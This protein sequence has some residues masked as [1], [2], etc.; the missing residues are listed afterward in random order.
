MQGYIKTYLLLGSCVL[1]LSACSTVSKVFDEKENPPIEGKRLSVL[2]LQK[3]LE[4]DSTAIEQ[5][6]VILPEIWQNE[7]WPQA[8]GLPNHAMHNLAWESGDVDVLWRADIGSGSHNEIPLTAQPVIVKDVIYA[9]DTESK[10]SAINAQNGKKIWGIDV[11]NKAEDEDVIGGGIAFANGMLFITNGSNEILSV[12]VSEGKIIWRANL[13]T[14]ARAA[15]TALGGRVFVST[16]DDRLFAIDAEKGT[17]IWDYLGIGETTGLLGAASPAANTSIVVPAFSSGE[18]TALRV[19]NGSV[20][21]SDNLANVR[22]FGGG[23]ESLSDIK[24]MPVMDRGVVIAMSFSDKLVAIEEHTGLRLWQ[25]EIGG[26][27]TP[28]VAGNAVFVLSNDNQLVALRLEDGAILW[29][30]QVPRYEDPD[31]QKNEIIWSSPVMASGNILLCGSHGKI[32]KYDAQTGKPAGSIKIGAAVQITPV[33][34]NG[35]MYV[36]AENGTLIAL[37]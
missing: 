23:L 28:W 31:D 25:R 10:L 9:L 29:V 2:A 37:R 36:L 6:G 20:V 12:S 15:P 17:V 11:S 24:A 27:A 1:S 19:E 7:Y 18:L 4:P 34:S 5:G 26:S 33:I 22:K 35:I 14:P 3:S 30:E 8:G 32:L 16:L 21:W 13:P